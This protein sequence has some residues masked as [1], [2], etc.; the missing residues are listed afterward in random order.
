MELRESPVFYTKYTKEEVKNKDKLQDWFDGIAAN[1]CRVCQRDGDCMRLLT[2]TNPR[3][4]QFGRTL[5]TCSCSIPIIVFQLFALVL[6][7]T[8]EFFPFSQSLLSVVTKTDRRCVLD[9]WDSSGVH[10]E[11]LLASV[12]SIRY[13]SRQTSLL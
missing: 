2:F 5:V 11:R 6:Y 8:F 3:V 4:K 12:A 10:C 1:K 13:V 7:R 9:V